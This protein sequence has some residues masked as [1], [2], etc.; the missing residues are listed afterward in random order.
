MKAKLHLPAILLAL[1]VSVHAATVK[2]REGAVRGE[3]AKME[4]DTRW[5]WS[6][7][8]GGFRMAKTTGKPLLVVLRCVPCLSCAGIDASV[9]QEPELVPLL[10]QFV[11][12][13]VINANA[14]D[15]AKFQ[16]DYDLS[17][18]AIMFN[19]DGTIYGRYG[20]WLHQKDP[21]NKTTASFKKALDATLAIH[22]DY[23]ANKATLTGKQGGPTP[24]Q[25]PV[26][27]PTLAAKYPS[28][29]DWEGKVMQSCVHCHMVGDAFRAHYRSQNK[30]VPV[31]W[32]Y[33]QPSTETLGITLATD[34]IA[35]VEA[36]APDSPAAKAGVQTGDTFTSLNGQPLVSIADVSWVLHRSPDSGSIPAKILR[37]GKET[38]LILDLPAGWR[39]KSDIG[40]RA[41]TWPMRAMAF[42]GMKMD[43]I[44]DA[45]RGTLGLS[46]DQMALRIFHVGQYGEH[47]KAKQAGFQKDDI[48]VEVGDLKQRITESA[49]IGHL[50]LHHLP[51]EK[52]PAAVM[53]GGKRVELKLPQQ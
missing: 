30:P 25:T 52:L 29:L 42:G 14:L 3:K 6:D 36:V 19:G 31:E 45:E 12:V 11:C 35:K 1:S 33:P 49:I 23:P 37:G 10:D 27:F 7:I 50:L 5:N 4:N 39:L 26:E 17:F 53:R 22:K 40:K 2:D 9:L 13:R 38:A 15:L 21:L 28:K 48:L 18:S 20:S 41:G 46:K 47:A 8:D 44:E 51:G 43:D 16:F 24:Y 34:D 32:I